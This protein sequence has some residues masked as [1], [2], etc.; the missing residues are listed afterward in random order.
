[1]SFKADCSKVRRILRRP[2]AYTAGSKEC[3]EYFMSLVIST[4]RD[5]LVENLYLSCL[6]GNFSPRLL[7]EICSPANP[8]QSS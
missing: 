6:M 7:A 2:K 5:T 1:M 8:P 3:A 4:G